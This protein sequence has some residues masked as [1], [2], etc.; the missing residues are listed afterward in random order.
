MLFLK[1]SSLK[2]KEIVVS[3]INY[4]NEQEVIDFAEHLSKQTVAERILLSITANKW[5]PNGRE[6]LVQGLQLIDIDTLLLDENNN[7]GYLNGTIL[8]YK[9]LRGRFDFSPRW[10]AVSNT[11]IQFADDRFMETLLTNQYAEDVGCIAP[12]VYVPSTG[13][14]EN[15]RYKIR[16]KRSEIQKI[17]KRFSS[18]VFMRFLQRVSA[19]K[20]KLLRGKEEPSQYVYLAHGC[21]FFVSPKVADTLCDR[22][23]SALLYTEE[24]FVAET[25]ITLGKRVFYDSSLKLFHNEN[26]VTGRLNPKKRAQMSIDSL[27]ML[28]RRFYCSEPCERQFVKD[29]VCAVIVSFNDP[30]KICGNV[31][32]L[33]EN[34]VLTAIVDNGSS[35]DTVAVLKD[36][37]CQYG[38]ELILN[39]ENYGIATALQ[40]GLIYAHNHGFKLMLTLDQDSVLCDGALAEMIRVM[41][42]DCSIASVGPSYSEQDIS[43]SEMD[44]VDVDYLI[45]SGNL[46]NINRTICCGGYD[47][48]FF[49]DSVDFEISLRLKN[50]GY[51]IV[52]APGAHLKHSIGEKFSPQG[53]FSFLKLERHSP[54]RFYYMVR[55]HFVLCKRY[56]K[57]FTLFCLKKKLSMLYEIGQAILFFPDKK[58]YYKAIMQGKADAKAGIM[59]KRK[60]G[61]L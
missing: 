5:S 16:L 13:I 12:S 10:I 27:N 58:E 52:K 61:F 28:L 19:I 7:L 6:F 44:P 14:F 60:G 26:A 3:V 56:N 20:G 4:G 39:G 11:D 42:S 15:P 48:T 55:N 43:A 37:A 25:A 35:D 51:R 49:I 41:N 22:P 59:G 50:N 47:E 2:D 53:F 38:C 54:L 36:I 45:T 40:Q 34:G 33:K 21:F 18:P 57:T 30:T 17:I 31:A 29:D 23:Y 46:V 32:M 1:K 24:S 8:G 9:K